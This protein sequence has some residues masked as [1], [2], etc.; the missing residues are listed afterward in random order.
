MTETITIV[1]DRGDNA[2]AT[3]FLVWAKYRTYPQCD[4]D[5]T[6]VA[7]I[8]ITAAETSVTYEWD[9]P[10]NNANWKFIAAPKNMEIVGIFGQLET[11]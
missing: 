3:S 6:F 1:V 5:G 2:M 4:G 7:E 9:A 10:N 11:A 8:P